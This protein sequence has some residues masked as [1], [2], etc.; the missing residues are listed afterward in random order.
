MCTPIPLRLRSSMRF[1]SLLA[2]LV[3]WTGGPR[4]GVAQETPADPELPEIAPR[5][6]E[7][8]G[9]FDVGFPSLE[10]QPLRGFAAPPT[11]PVIPP[12]R[13]PY[14][15]TY[16]QGR[17]DLPERLPPPPTVETRLSS[18]PPPANGSIEAGVGRYFRRFAEGRVT[19]PLNKTES[20]EVDA[21]YEGSEGFE[22]VETSSA[23]TKHDDLDGSLRLLSRR[24]SATTEVGVRAFSST[25]DLYGTRP[26]AASGLDGVPSRDVFSGGVFAQLDT[27]GRL[28]SRIGVTLDQMQV[29]TRGSGAENITQEQQRVAL[30][31]EAA[32]PFG[33]QEIRAHAHVAS[34]G[35]GSGAFAGDIT[36][37]DLGGS[38]VAYREGPTVIRAG[39]R[40]L[41]YDAALPT[42]FAR[43]ESATATF[44]APSAE[45]TI[46]VS[47]R[48]TLS[49]TN[50]PGLEANTLLTVHQST[51]W[52]SPG[53]ALR[54]TLYTTRAQAGV[55]VSTG[56]LR[57]TSYAGYRYAPSF[58]FAAPSA[59]PEFES[60][61][62]ETLYESARF[63]EA[64]ASISL[65][66][67]DPF[68]AVL[69]ARI[70]DGQLVERDVAI[71]YYSPLIAEAGLSYRFQ[72]RKALAQAQLVIE[73][74][75]YADFSETDEVGTIVD[76]DLRGSYAVSP[77]LDLVARIENLGAS[78]ERY[79][80]YERPSTI[81]SGGIRIHW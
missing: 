46:A 38:A 77:I 10:R 41:T 62:F 63:A 50:R 25:F 81:V 39:A 16:K 2:I 66:G 61:V 43:R 56:M 75:R 8:R 15:A 64:G 13:M 23:F 4:A 26:T 31:A 78:F 11:V 27:H 18:A 36:S 20:V 73:S 80:N 21:A 47:P 49:V 57:L 71:P 40:L 19:F 48:F 52:L 58:A 7:I 65:Q 45:L 17:S 30:D 22:P 5:E 37:L 6:I 69:R 32:L 55:E 12:E 72:D 34:S 54:P 42:A 79:Q 3:L 74:P 1:L 76:L 35:L 33:T 24:T 9:Q 70:R 59:D 60:G 53:V 28:K 68:Q 44:I 67:A 51:P 29:D 14:T